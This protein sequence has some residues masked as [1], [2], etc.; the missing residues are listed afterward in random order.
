MSMA[1]PEADTVATRPPLGAVSAQTEN[2]PHPK[3]KKGASGRAKSWADVVV[4][5]GFRSRGSD[6]TTWGSRSSL[7][8]ATAKRGSAGN[9]PPLLPAPPNRSVQEATSLLTA[10][11][12]CGRRGGTVEE[13]GLFALEACAADPGRALPAGRRAGLEARHLPLPCLRT[14]PHLPPWTI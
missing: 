12:Y 2:S 3:L 5:Y 1:A 10:L 6:I 7:V 11:N 13:A 9:V 8:E 4:G 14:A